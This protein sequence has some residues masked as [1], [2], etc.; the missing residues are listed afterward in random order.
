MTYYFASSNQPSPLSRVSASLNARPDALIL[1][2]VIALG[3]ILPTLALLMLDP[4]VLDDEAL[5][6]KPLKFQISM[7]MFCLTVWFGVQQLPRHWRASW[8]LRVPSIL[9]AST[10][11]YE[12]MFLAIQAGRGKRSHFNSETIFDQIGGSIMAA[13]AGVLVSG[14]AFIGVIILLYWLKHHART[15]TGPLV[16]A[17][18]LGLI[19]GGILG[20]YTGSYIGMNRGPFVGPFDPTQST[21]AL[22]GWALNIGDLRISHFFG[23]HAMQALPLIAWL[24]VHVAA[25]P[26]ARA[27]IVLIGASGAWIWLTLH[28]LEAALAGKPPF[29]V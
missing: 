9:V 6:L 10:A 18:A 20:G 23:L 19:L 25:L 22:V 1:A 15:F 11:L 16:L 29:L 21:I 14:A 27:N 13:G 28:T 2:T 3:M 7:A 26:T 24:L 17:F 5:W 8:W 12:L 4:R